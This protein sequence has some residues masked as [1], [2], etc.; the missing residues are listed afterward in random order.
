MSRWRCASRILTRRASGSD[1]LQVR[2]DAFLRLDALSRRFNHSC[3]ANAALRQS[4]NLIALVDIPK[5]TEITFDYAMT[6]VPAIWSPF[7]RVAC[8]CAER[9]CRGHINDLASVPVEVVRRHEEA[10]ALN[11]YVCEHL[12]ARDGNET[13]HRGVRAQP[14]QHVI[15]R[16][17]IED[18]GFLLEGGR[19][20]V[21]LLHGL[22]G[23]P[24][25]MR[26]V[27]E[28]LN[29]AGFTVGCPQ[30]A[31]HCGSYDDLRDTLWTDWLRSAELGLVRLHAQ[32]DFV[33]V[34]GLSNGAVL[35]LYLAAER[36]QLVNGLLLY[37]PTLWLNGWVVPLHAHLF[38][39][40]RHKMLANRFDFPDLPP[41]GIKDPLIRQR[42]HDAMHSGDSAAAGVPVTP[43]AAVLEHRRLVKATLARLGSI[44][45]PTLVVHPREDD[46]ADLN[47]VLHLMRRL[48]GQVDT[49]VLEDSY[50]IVTADRQRDVVIERS[51]DYVERLWRQHQKLHVATGAASELALLG[52]QIRPVL[53]ASPQ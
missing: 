24:N 13:D 2:R 31:G 22:G 29:A 30:L 51:I 35:G 8:T 48:A 23:T 25:E 1:L 28:G 7:R 27:A 5:G 9:D 41:H 36:P 20:G 6:R 14:Q 33:V 50:H 10:G 11:D 18:H 49:V 42:I 44:H 4:N 34:G 32:C 17:P 47:N 37:A 26:E 15:R 45:Q 52:Q 53:T 3:T 12:S 38:H 19:V 40:V 43:G 16:A 46:Y 21:L 39:L